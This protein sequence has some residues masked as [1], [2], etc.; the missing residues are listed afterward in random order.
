MKKKAK[1][2]KKKKYSTPLTKISPIRFSQGWG[3]KSV[4]NSDLY[5]EGKAR[6]ACEVRIVSLIAPENMLEST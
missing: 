1:K 4:S 3:L 2:K 5:G 6:P